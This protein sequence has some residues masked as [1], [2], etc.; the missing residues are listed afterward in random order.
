ML[1]I[2]CDALQ[3]A[4]CSNVDI[5][6][7]CRSEEFHARGCWVL[8]LLLDQQYQRAGNQQLPGKG[9]FGRL[10]GAVGL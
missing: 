6:T 3:D 10:R 4:G 2:L 9:F 7:H 1:P 8:D 5:I